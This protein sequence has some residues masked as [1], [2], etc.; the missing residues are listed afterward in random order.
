MVLR[1][2]VVVAPRPEENAIPCSAF[3]SEA[4]AV[5]SAGICQAPTCNENVENGTD[6][7]GD[8]MRDDIDECPEEAEDVDQF[9]DEDGCPDIDNDKDGILDVEGTRKQSWN[10]SGDHATWT[11]N[12][13]LVVAP[14]MQAK[15]R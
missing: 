10:R 4:S 14:D 2:S 3:S 15:P 7:D 6:T 8:G 1:I 9:E 12:D 11:R 13:D 5:C